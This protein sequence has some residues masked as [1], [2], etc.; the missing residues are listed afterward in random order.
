MPGIF[1]RVAAQNVV[2]NNKNVL[3]K[4][5]DLFVD[6]YDRWML[7]SVVFVSLRMMF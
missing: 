4:L 2:Q 5:F 6:S 1:S 3:F 7:I